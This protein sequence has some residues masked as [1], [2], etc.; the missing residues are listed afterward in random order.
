MPVLFQIVTLRTPD[1]V[2]GDCFQF[3]LRLGGAGV[4]HEHWTGWWAQVSATRR[5]RL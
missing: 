4:E 1:G 2:T 3:W 5:L